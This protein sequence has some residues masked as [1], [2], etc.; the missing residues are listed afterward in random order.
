MLHWTKFDENSKFNCVEYITGRNHIAETKEI[1]TFDI[2]TTSIWNINGNI[3]SYKDCYSEKQYNNAESKAFCYIWQFGI[4][5]TV[6]YGRYLSELPKFLQKVKKACKSLSP[7]IWVHNLSYEFQFI[8]EY[9]EEIAPITVFARSERKPIKFDWDIFEFRCTYMLTRKSLETW[10]K[11]LGCT[12]MVGDLDYNI[13]RT[14]K[15]PMTK[16][17]M[18]YCERDCIV[19]YHGIRDL[20]KHMNIS[21]LSL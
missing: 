17:E 18:G 7:I 15:T 16:T 10:G 1:L 2:E 14:Q 8:R 20:L 4:D 12:K 5:D 6:Y 19:V 11:E 3:V 9:L 21:M 13:L